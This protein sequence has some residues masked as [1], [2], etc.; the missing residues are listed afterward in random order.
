MLVVRNYVTKKD[1]M[2]PLKIDSSMYGTFYLGNANVIW[3]L[4]ELRIIILVESVVERPL[5]V[6]EVEVLSL[7][8][9]P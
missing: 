9:Q 8:K 5:E 7:T 3:C 1:G 4:S 2:H 6:I